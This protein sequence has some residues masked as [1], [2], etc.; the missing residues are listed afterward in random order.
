MNNY[1]RP[2]AQADWQAHGLHIHREFSNLAPAEVAQVLK[3]AIRCKYRQPKTSSN[4]AAAFWA[5]V[6]KAYYKD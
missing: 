6:Q 2:D 3:W 5:T 1:S 4:R